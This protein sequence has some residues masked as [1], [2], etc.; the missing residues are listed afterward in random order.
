MAE[1]KSTPQEAGDLV[2]ALADLLETERTHLREG[3][4]DEVT[5]LAQRKEELTAR[6]EAGEATGAGALALRDLQASAA[7]NGLLL[8]A[9]TDGMR[10]AAARLRFLTEGPEPLST[11]DP[12]GRRQTMGPGK[13]SVTKRA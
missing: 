13:S 11:Y 6:I 12:A 7:R 3:H 4:L 10:D 9:A 5:R 2:G 8:R 1:A